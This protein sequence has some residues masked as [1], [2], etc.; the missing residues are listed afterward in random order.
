MHGH[1]NRNYA[2]HR[3]N[4]DIVLP[5]PS[6]TPIPVSSP[7]TGG[8]VNVAVGGFCNCNR[9][10]RIITTRQLASGPPQRDGTSARRCASLRI[11]TRAIDA[12]TGLKVAE[13]MEVGI[14]DEPEACRLNRM[15]V[16]PSVES[17]QIKPSSLKSSK[18]FTE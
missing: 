4:S 10:D 13:R 18:H 15:S 11:F 14:A 6:L 1:V 12:R 9:A 5:Y 2:I 17:N 7:R 16:G 8:K 3:C